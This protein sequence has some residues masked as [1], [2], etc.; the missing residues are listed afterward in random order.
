[1][2]RVVLADDEEFVRYFLKSV[3]ASLSFKVVAEVENGNKLFS[4]MKKTHP[5][6]L[7]LDINM[8]NITGIEFLR[9]HASKFPKTCVIILTSATSFKLM[10]EAS[11][12]GA[13]C[14]LRKDMPIEKMVLAIE[15]TWTTFK[16]ENQ[17]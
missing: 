2:V 8:P 10:E 14:F 16:E 17:L 13:S 6:I 9:E 11:T 4:V 12:D 3:M 7:F 1:M 15:K 5:D